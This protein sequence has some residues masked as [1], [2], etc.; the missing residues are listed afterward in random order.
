MDVKIRRYKYNSF[1]MDREAVPMVVHQTVYFN[2]S[3][4]IINLL[5][6]CKVFQKVYDEL[7]YFF[8]DLNEV[9]I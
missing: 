7:F 6:S 3:V 9:P 2:C 1:H 5:V 4:N 8:N